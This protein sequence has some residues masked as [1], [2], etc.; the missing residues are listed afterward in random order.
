MIKV[1]FVRIKKQLWIKR[2][3]IP[4]SALAFSSY[5]RDCMSATIKFLIS[6][7]LLE[8]FLLAFSFK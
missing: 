7:A 4:R 6:L 8:L 2:I 5:F 3:E 1:S